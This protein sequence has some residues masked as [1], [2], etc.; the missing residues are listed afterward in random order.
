MTVPFQVEKTFCGDVGRG[1]IPAVGW[2]CTAPVV[3]GRRGGFPED[4][5]FRDMFL[6][7]RPKRNR[8]SRRYFRGAGH[9]SRGLRAP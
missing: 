2:S 1:F 5:R 3:C 8:K 6:F 7:D 9:G 4:S